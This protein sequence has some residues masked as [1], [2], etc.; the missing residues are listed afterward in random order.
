[1]S[2][3]IRHR[4]RSR[5]DFT[6]Y[7]DRGRYDPGLQY[8]R[9]LLLHPPPLQRQSQVAPS[10]VPVSNDAVLQDLL[11]TSSEEQTNII[12]VLTQGNAAH[13]RIFCRHISKHQLTYTEPE[14]PSVSPGC[15]CSG[16]CSNQA[17][18]ESTREPSRISTEQRCLKPQDLPGAFGKG[19]RNNSS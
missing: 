4:S 5:P 11:P 9:C 15:H 1:M 3:S 8:R 14:G 18:A 17:R 19:R 2:C 16:P 10:R 12:Q 6:T 7:R 13:R